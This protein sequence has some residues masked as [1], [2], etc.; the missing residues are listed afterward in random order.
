M[1]FGFLALVWNCALRR[2]QS[3][4]Q[5]RAPT[6]FFAHP[7]LRLFLLR[8][9]PTR[10]PEEVRR[11]K[12]STSHRRA[13][14]IQKRVPVAT[15][16]TSPPVTSAVAARNLIGDHK[17]TLISIAA[18]AGIFGD[19]LHEAFGHGVTAYL[20]GAQKLTLS[21]VA[22]Q[23][24]NDT[25]LIAAMGTV[26][27]LIAGA[28]L[29]LF[30]RRGS[31][32]KP[33]TRYF[34]VM[35]MAGNLMAGTGYFFFSGITNFGDWARV[36][37]GLHPYWIWRLGLIVI[38]AASYYAVTILTATELRPFLNPLDRPRLRRLTWIPYF[39]DGVLATIAGLLNPA[40][41]FYVI[42]S[43]VP[44]TLGAKTGLFVE[45]FVMHGWKLRGDGPVAPIGRSFAWIT[46][47]AIAC[48]FYIFVLGRGITWTR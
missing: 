42:A 39:T 17:L 37:L 35:A 41:A 23:S 44:S 31:R 45:P 33:A 6:R 4:A 30:L 18:L 22:L 21:T 38:G 34:L 3:N 12:R 32:Y 46:C 11:I 20:S 47:S 28:I 1:L 9:I 13:S 24:D 40:G 15:P 36:I 5:A 25:R 14:V 16:A 19:I 26:V 43:A 10:M 7:Q 48:V 8:H 29:W 27:N 2:R